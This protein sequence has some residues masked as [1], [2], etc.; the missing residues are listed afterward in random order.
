MGRRGLA[1]RGRGLASGGGEAHRAGNAT[2]RRRELFDE[3]M[4]AQ[5]TAALAAD[6]DTAFEGVVLAH[7]DRLYSIALR[8]LGDPG[9]A[10]EVAQDAFVR[11][12]RA[13]SA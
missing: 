3:M 11:A 4:D 8:L 12:Y 1:V 10:E 5:L 13:L 2:A 9:D 6:L 7:Q